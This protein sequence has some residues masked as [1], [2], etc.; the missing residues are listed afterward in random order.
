MSKPEVLL[1]GLSFAEAPRWRDDHIDRVFE[2]GRIAQ[3]VPTGPRDSCACMRSGRQ[4]RTLSI[5]TNTGS[6]PAMASKADGRFEI[7]D[8]DVPGAGLP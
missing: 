3:R 1:D 2:G 4:R 6:G 5:L 7:V 8:V